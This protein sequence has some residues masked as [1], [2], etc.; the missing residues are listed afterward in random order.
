MTV[1]AQ[2]NDYVVGIDTHSKTHTLAIIST[3]TGG[4]T[5]N[6]TFPSTAAGM[7][8]AV[9][10]ISRRSTKDPGRVLISMEGTG[11]YGAKLR[12]FATQAG[13]RLIEAPFP[14]RRLS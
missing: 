14:Q 5:A 6:E 9:T 7:A 12:Q 3:L 2:T 11:S 4:E 13:Y 1:V 8:R 10:W